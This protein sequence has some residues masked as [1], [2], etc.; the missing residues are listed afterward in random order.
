MG[1][2]IG[3]FLQSVRSEWREESV[4]FMLL[5]KLWGSFG[6]MLYCKGGD[7]G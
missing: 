7:C 2:C 5:C 3:D 1:G 4:G 6:S